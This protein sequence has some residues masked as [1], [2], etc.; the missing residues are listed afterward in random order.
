MIDSDA[1]GNFMARAFV[2]KEDYST[3]KK[4]DVYNLM[5]VDENPL[6]D[7]NERVNKETKLLSIAI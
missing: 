7:E 1:T 2:E 6:L 4:P 3:Q 5:I